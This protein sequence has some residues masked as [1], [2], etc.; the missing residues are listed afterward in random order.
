M[1]SNDKLEKGYVVALGNFDGLHKGHM[2]VINAAKNM[3]AQTGA[4]PC[5]CTFIEH[6]LKELKG[7]AP[8]ALFDGGV[9]EEIFCNTG[10]KVIRLE[11]TA[12]KDMSPEE[13]FNEVLIKNLNAKGV[14]C[15]FDYNFGAK[16]AGT[17]E[18]LE[19]LC[20]EAGISFSVSPAMNVDGEPISSTRIRQALSDGNIE[21][22]NRMLGRPYK[23]RQRVVDG[24]K[25]GRTWGM[26]TINQPY[27]EDLVVPRF[28]VYATRCIID[29]IDYYGATNIGVSPTVKVGEPVTA[30]TY[31]LEYDGDLYGKYVD[32][33]L[34]E[35]LR[36][37]ERFESVEEL[38][39]QMEKDIEMVRALSERKILPLQ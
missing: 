13:F 3:A 25:R 4:E 37:E 29:G 9:K 28:G 1:Y 23:F 14:C 12:V 24:E 10:I 32:I 2:A 34:L 27:P 19:K 39:E 33:C 20:K 6:P 7:Q 36:P 31:I 8:P 18:L 17:P 21:L 15:G 16:G 38:K 30:E 5:I 11:F 35:F 22:A 26:P